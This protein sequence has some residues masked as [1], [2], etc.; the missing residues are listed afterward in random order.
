LLKN[1]YNHLHKGFIE[2]KNKLIQNLAIDQLHKFLDSHYIKD[3]N[4]RRIGRTRQ[5]T[6][7]S[8]G[9]ETA[10]DISWNDIINIP[11]FGKSYT[12]SLVNWR[13]YLEKQFR[14]NPSKGIDPGD[15]NRIRNKYIQKQRIIETI[16]LVGDDLLVTIKNDCYKNR[17]KLYAL[18]YEAAKSVAQ[19]KADLSIF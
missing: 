17:Q 16:L 12:S 10:A 2:E 7:A 18:I 13:K 4:I 11:G 6:L 5:A 1:K 3:H 15:L 19:A 8:F 9:I 14:F